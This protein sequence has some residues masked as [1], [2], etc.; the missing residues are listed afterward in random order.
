V[1]I[2]GAEDIQQNYC[3]AHRKSCAQEK[4]WDVFPRKTVQPTKYLWGVLSTKLWNV[5]GLW[6]KNSQLPFSTKIHFVQ[7]FFKILYTLAFIR[8]YSGAQS[9]Y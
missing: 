7:R 9:F 3:G 8:N 1:P 6:H 5:W 2:F 4:L